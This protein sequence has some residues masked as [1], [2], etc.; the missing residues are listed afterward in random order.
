MEKWW[1]DATWKKLI[2]R[3]GMERGLYLAERFKNEFGYKY[4]YPFPI[5]GRKDGGKMMYFMVH[6]S[7]HLDATPIMFRAYKKSIGG[8]PIR[9]VQPELIARPS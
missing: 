9:L 8:N 3:R 7:D 6:A 2:E 4:A 1:G 5:F